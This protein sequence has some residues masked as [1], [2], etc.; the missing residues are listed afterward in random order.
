M[1]QKDK[2]VKQLAKEKGKLILICFILSFIIETIFMSA[3]PIYNVGNSDVFIMFTVGRA[4]MRGRVP[5]KDIYDQKGPFQFYL[6]GISSLI[7]E[8]GM[9]GVYLVEVVILA[10]G[11]YWVYK[12]FTL[13]L[14]DKQ[15]KIALI[16]FSLLLNDHIGAYISG[17]IETLAIPCFAYTF[18]AVIKNLRE[19]NLPSKK[20]A[21]GIGFTMGVILLS[22]FLYIMFYVGCCITPLIVAIKHKKYKDI[23]EDL[24]Y[25]FLGI[26]I[27]FI[28]FAIYFI[29]NGAFI[30][31]IREYFWDNL[32]MY[33]QKKAIIEKLKDFI[34]GT[35]GYALIFNYS[36]PVLF[37]IYEMCRGKWGKTK[38]TIMVTFWFMIFACF[39]IRKVWLYYIKAMAIFVV[40]GIIAIW[41]T[42]KDKRIY[43]VIGVVIGALLYAEMFYD[44][45]ESL[46][47][48][49]KLN[50]KYD[51]LAETVSD[52]ITEDSKVIE[53][54]FMYSYIFYKYNIDPYTKYFTGLNV[55][56]DL[57]KEKALEDISNKKVDIVVTC[58]RLKDENYIMVGKEREVN[59][60]DRIY[61]YVLKDLL[62]AN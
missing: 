10:I 47:D 2:N 20:E 7:D 25:I 19:N 1:E 33:P 42:I 6:Y 9:L 60:Q 50:E 30:D 31:F 13:W 58:D 43:V 5:Y 36:L 29:C 55:H 53:Y 17:Q 37:T 49:I 39:G 23:L 57:A 22:K 27:L 38:T 35:V 34:E 12:L 54:G 52:V 15:S 51:R 8:T 21:L 3:S 16:V 62:K 56:G 41:N 28:P 26:C 32:T 44:S 59:Y 48:C 14:N 18:Y 11:F 24:L 45:M 61:V 4:V 40:F 46:V